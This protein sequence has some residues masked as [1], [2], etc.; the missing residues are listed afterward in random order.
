MTRMHVDDIAGRL[1]LHSD[2]WRVLRLPA[3]AE[4]DDPLGRNAGEPL[5]PAWESAAELERKREAIG[6]RA[7]S[8]LY[9][10]RP[11]RNDASLFRPDK[12]ELCEVCPDNA[13]YVRAWDL[14][15]TVPA[16][17]RDP[18]WTV[19]LKLGRTEASR[20]IIADVVRLRGGPY[21]VEE[22]IRT[23]AKRDGLCVPI[24]LPQDPGQAGKLQVAWLAGRLAGYRV[25]ASPETGSKQVRALPMAAQIEAGNVAM[26]RAGW[27]RA[28]LDE[29]AEF[30]V[31]GKDDQVDA[32][33]R[34][35][36][37]LSANA[38]PARRLRVPL[39]AR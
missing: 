35:F 20:Y 10:Q 38:P 8:A 31:G 24:S 22:A 7:W 15:A 23:T 34:A 25:S 9:Q 30:P 18:D 32:L 33:A 12:I 13:R 39:M 14:A 21:D 36:G 27:N 1:M 37:I 2:G 5:W 4:P 26:I 3:L 6:E 11:L 28:L 19:G 17:G 16:A 29:L